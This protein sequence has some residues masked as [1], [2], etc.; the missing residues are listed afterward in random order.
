MHSSSR[1]ALPRNEANNPETGATRESLHAHSRILFIAVHLLHDSLTSGGD[2]LFAHV[3]REIAKLRPD[4]SI[5]VIGP[6]YCRSALKQYFDVVLE[7]PANRAEQ[8]R[9]DAHRSLIIPTWFFRGLVAP[10]HARAFR[11]QV[12]HCT[13]DFFPDIMT[14]E[15]LKAQRNCA[16]TGVVHHVNANPRYRQNSLLAATASF[17]MQRWSFSR[18]R[19]GAD[20]VFLLNSQT[21]RELTDLGFSENRLRVIGAGIDI[22]RFPLAPPPTG[23]RRVLWV[24]RIEP[25]KGIGDLP[26]VVARLPAD[27]VVDIVGQGPTFWT[28]LLKKELQ[29]EG[30]AGRVILHGYVDDCRLSELYRSASVFISCSHEEGWGLSICEALAV[31]IPCVAYALQSH[32]EV[33]RDAVEFVPLRDTAAFASK[34]TALLDVQD[35]P[36]QRQRRRDRVSAYTFH[37]VARHYVKA[38]DFLLNSTEPNG[39]RGNPGAE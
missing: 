4:W 19:S 21:R 17:A 32:L 25:T 35:T 6:S 13:G 24:H 12:V 38:F 7:V 31:G 26:K 2:I 27:V 16:W 9:L 11:P 33:F 22:D 18:L 23:Q 36:E 34:V 5:G 8:V 29:S 14:A 3:A 39:S 15:R 1:D 28:D 30:V 20:C 37:N 10:P